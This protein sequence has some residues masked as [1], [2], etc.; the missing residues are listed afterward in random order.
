M[1]YHKNF[2]NIATNMSTINLNKIIFK[3][4]F[5]FLLLKKY[6]SN[7]AMIPTSSQCSQISH[8]WIEIKINHLTYKKQTNVTNKDIILYGAP[9]MEKGSPLSIGKINPWETKWAW[10]SLLVS[11]PS[12][13]PL[14]AYINPN[15]SV[16]S[17]HI[18][19]LSFLFYF[20]L[21]FLAQ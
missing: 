8:F 10:P 20:S 19:I 12:T 17:H 13:T 18:I 15:I 21:F 3:N 7:V 11:L 1:M 16:F 5:F 9:G 2:I 14:W 4:F 6:F